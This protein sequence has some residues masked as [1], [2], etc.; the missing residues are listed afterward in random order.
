M[1]YNASVVVL[2]DRLEEI[3]RDPEFGKKLAAAIRH[4]NAYGVTRDRP[5][6]PYVTGQTE[7]IAV[8]HAD[9][10]QV[11]AIGANSGRLIGRGHWTQDNDELIQQL[12]RER[13]E[14]NRQSEA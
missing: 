12:E 8:E 3:E 13:L 10:L 5:S 4:R 9:T 11:V 6:A 2:V 7:I 1:G 14:R